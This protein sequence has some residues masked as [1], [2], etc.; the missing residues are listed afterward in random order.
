[1]N[2][3]KVILAALVIFAAGVITGGLVVGH[4][5]HT[6]RLKRFG[7]FRPHVAIAQT[8]AIATREPGRAQGLPNPVPQVLRKDF[9]QKLDR[10]VHLTPEQRE[11][12]EKI[13]KEGQERAKELWE[14]IAPLMREEMMKVREGIH[15]VLNEKQFAHFEQLM[16]P[17]SPE[18]HRLPPPPPATN[19]VPDT[20]P[21]RPPQNP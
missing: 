10:E 12:I 9:L 8:N 21:G 15:D 3:W 6:W 1:M 16:K 17:K 11:Q 4:A 19:S 18:A 7:L 20:P 2:S 14:P 13:I 5:D